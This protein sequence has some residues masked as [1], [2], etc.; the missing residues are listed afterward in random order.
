MATET[1]S[2]QGKFLGILTTVYKREVLKELLDNPEYSFTVN[3]ITKE[4]SGSYNSVKNFLRDL[5]DFN[6]ARFNKKGNTYL[7]KYNQGSRYHEVIKDL[8]RADRQPL[9]DAAKKFA[10]KLYEDNSSSI[11]SIILFGSVARGTAEADSDIDIL[12]ITEEENA[13]IDENARKYGERYIDIE[14]ELVPLTETIEDF[15]EKLE[16]GERFEENVAKD[17][18]VLKGDKLGLKD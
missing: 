7:V 10:S 3:E 8:F 1:G 5:E 13:G 12:V 18:V 2:K 11:R 6:I 16:K 17:G 15:R 14:N 4:V 9:E